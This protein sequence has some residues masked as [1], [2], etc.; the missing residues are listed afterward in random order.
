MKLPTIA[1]L[2]LCTAAAHAQD[3]P[4][5]LRVAPRDGATYGFVIDRR[6]SVRRGPAYTYDEPRTRK[7]VS[8]V[9]VRRGKS[10][11]PGR[12]VL[13][14]TFLRV[15]GFESGGSLDEEITFDRKADDPPGARPE[16][17]IVGRTVHVE[18]EHDGK[19]V[20]VRGVDEAMGESSVAAAAAIGDLRALVARLP[21]GPHP[22]WTTST[23]EG[24]GLLRVRI[25]AKH[26]IERT[27]DAESLITVS[28]KINAAPD[29]AGASFERSFRV[30]RSERTA[31]YRIS[32]DDGLPLEGRV[33][34]DY[35]VE[36]RMSGSDMQVGVATETVVTVRRIAVPGA[37]TTGAAAPRPSPRPQGETR[38][39]GLP[40]WIGTP[41]DT[42]R[43][44][45]GE[46][47]R[48]GSGLMGGAFDTFGELGLV[49]EYD[50]DGFVRRIAATKISHGVAF[51]GEL[52]GVSLGAPL[53]RAERLWGEATS[54]R[55]TRS[56]YDVVQF[57]FDDLLLD[58]E[59]WREDG[60]DPAF[61][62]FAA[63]TI[64]RIR[65]T[66]RGGH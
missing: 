3:A 10:E 48:T 21:D 13:D 9:R 40:A 7:I 42:V 55:T 50:D 4:P 29:G 18:V 17:H 11:S 36:A 20:A 61:G 15:H 52:L 47:T 8:T 57:V 19:L 38:N 26:A 25:E 51:A 2:V 16:T 45:A 58:I 5:P 53:A 33:T 65:V 39:R 30:S 43:K 44:L 35:A 28:G 49:Y 66:S 63:D 31:R 41:R 34:T 22:T 56:N 62:E 27:T 14:V 60:S 24:R 23:L 32:R 59:V 64:K 46:P 1:A 12:V 37:E 54:R 6:T